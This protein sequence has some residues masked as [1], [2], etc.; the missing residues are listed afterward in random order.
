MDGPCFCHT[1]IV[2]GFPVMYRCVTEKERSSPGMDK[3]EA[4]DRL[5]RACLGEQA[6]IL[7]RGIRIVRSVVIARV[8]SPMQGMPVSELLFI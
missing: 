3:K 6:S 2:A 1:V 4:F 5:L 7:R 8:I